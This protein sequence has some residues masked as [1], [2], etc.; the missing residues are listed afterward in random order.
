MRDTNKSSVIKK[1]DHVA[2]AVRL[3][4][5]KKWAWFHTVMEDGKLIQKIDDV[6]PNDPDSS[7]MLWCINY[8]TFGIALVA[9][10]DRKKES[11]VTS[12]IKKHGDHAVQHVA[13]DTYN[14]ESFR[15]RLKEFNGKLRGDVLIGKDAFGIYKQVFGKGYDAEK[16]PAQACFPEY[17][18]RPATKEEEAEITFSQ[19]AGKG[20]YQQIEDASEKKDTETL[21]GF[22][23]I[24]SDW[25]P[26]VIE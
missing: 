5:I 15:E 25:E 6:R 19:R 24:P 12:F 14:L 22:L 20:F 8:G 2:Y 3:E 10:I 18:Q 13:Y 1:I 21:L 7:M 16:D 9:G 17:V 23:S 11:Q 26:I 4:T